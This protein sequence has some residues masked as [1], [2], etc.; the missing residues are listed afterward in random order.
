MKR[1]IDVVFAIVCLLITTP[2]IILIAMLIRLESKGAVFYSPTMVGHNGKLF[3]LYRFRTISPSTQDHESDQRLTRV[4]ALLRNYSFDHL[5]ILI[6]VLKG[7]LSIIGP[8]PMEL[9][10]VDYSDP[11]WQKY[12][13]VKPG[14]FNYAVLKLGKSWTPSRIS[15]PSLNQNLEFEYRQ[16]QA[17]ILDLQLIIQFL[18][19]YVASRGNIK[20]RGTPDP[21]IESKWRE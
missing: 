6:N 8:R 17:S 12:F 20:A 21:E 11:I 4:G 7:D 1:V 3:S 2:L 10:V 9:D 16:K 5:P 15:D 14:L 18:R 19:A 13:Q